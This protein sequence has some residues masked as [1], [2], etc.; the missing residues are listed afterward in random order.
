MKEDSK[1]LL[2]N[3]QSKITIIYSQIQGIPKY[4]TL[5][6]LSLLNSVTVVNVK[7][8]KL[9]KISHQLLR[10]KILMKMKAMIIIMKKL[11]S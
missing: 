4:L 1:A 6:L 11:D 5:L 7:S 2:K 9:I 10:L 8:V 3:C